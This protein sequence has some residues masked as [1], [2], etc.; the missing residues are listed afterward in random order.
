MLMQVT[1]IKHT[2]THTHTHTQPENKETWKE[3]KFWRKDKLIINDKDWFGRQ[4]NHLDKWN[5]EKRHIKVNKK[6]LKSFR[7]TYACCIVLRK[8]TI[9]C[10]YAY[11]FVFIILI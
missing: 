11:N 9:K 1:L 7:S 5:C 8:K 10:I 6:N 3:E 2:H 4:Y